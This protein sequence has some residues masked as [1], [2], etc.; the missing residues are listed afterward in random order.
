MKKKFTFFRENYKGEIEDLYKEA[1]AIVI[2]EKRGSAS[3][4]QRKLRIG[5]GKAAELLDMLE[6]RCVVGKMNGAK[7]RELLAPITRA[8]I[9]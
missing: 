2:E 9:L 5:Y 3:L 1:K 6:E 4:L 7:P 8:L